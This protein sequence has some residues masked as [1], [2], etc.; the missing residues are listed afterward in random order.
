MGGAILGIFTKAR[1]QDQFANHGRAAR[2]LRARGLYYLIRDY[3]SDKSYVIIL[4]LPPLKTNNGGSNIGDIYKGSLTR[5][6]CELWS[7]SPRSPS[8]GSLLLDPRLFFR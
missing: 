1:L 8:A 5:A 6:V 4:L 3:F 2:D 7:G